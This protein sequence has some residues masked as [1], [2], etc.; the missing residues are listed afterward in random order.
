MDDVFWDVQYLMFENLELSDLLSLSQTS[1]RFSILTEEIFMRKHSNKLFRLFRPERDEK[2]KL[3][4][5]SDLIIVI[6]YDT[7]LKLLK[8]FGR[9]I[10]NIELLCGS[11]HEENMTELSASINLNCAD[12]LIEINIDSDHEDL[13]AGMTKPFRKLKVFSMRGLVENLGSDTLSFNELFPAIR[14][15]KLGNIVQI[16]NKSCID[17]SFE[18]L[19][20]LDVRVQN[21]GLVK[22]LN[23]EDVEKLLRKNPQI[24]SILLRNAK[25]RL[26]ELTSQILPN[27][28][29]IHLISYDNT[30]SDGDHEIIFENLTNFTAS[31]RSQDRYENVTFRNLTE[32][33]TGISIF[34]N[35]EILN[36][37]TFV[38]RNPNLKRLF[39]DWGFIYHGNIQQL[40]QAQLNIEEITMKILSVKEEH[41]INFIRNCEHMKKITVNDDVCHYI[42]IETLRDQI[43]DKWIITTH[44]K[45]LVFTRRD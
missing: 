20:Y 18:H 5:L 23:S 6:N 32:L 3:Y 30:I 7:I 25:R 15:L 27:I 43:E 40:S 4:D 14:R 38:R 36:L 45:R 37:I 9:L 1:Q 2:R 10:K 22:E 13:F 44:E 29:D 41:I 28:A 33:H 31:F 8:T 26:L 19:E 39:I 16:S 34:P 12:T 11:S 35:D 24:Q 17:V 42:N 21:Y